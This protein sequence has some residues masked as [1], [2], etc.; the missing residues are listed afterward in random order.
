MLIMV[1]RLSEKL[2]NDDGGALLAMEFLFM[3]VILVIGIIVGLVGV[4]NAIV[5]ELTAL[6][7]AIL[8]LNVGFSFGGLSGCCSSTPGSQAIQIIEQLIPPVC[9]PPTPTIIDVPPCT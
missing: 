8:A 7:D 2:W 9:V 6:G 1:R 3:A 5:A 4:R